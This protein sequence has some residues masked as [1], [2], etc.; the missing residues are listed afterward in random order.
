MSLYSFQEYTETG[1]HLPLFSIVLDR[2]EA[3]E[4]GESETVVLSWGWG[5]TER[6]TEPGA[7]RL[8]PTMT[9][10]LL[11]AGTD[12]NLGHDTCPSQLKTGH[13][14]RAGGPSP[15]WRW[16]ATRG[17]AS[18]ECGTWV[19]C[20]PGLPEQASV[21]IPEET[22]SYVKDK[23]KTSFCLWSRGDDAVTLRSWYRYSQPPGLCS[24][25]ES[26][27]HIQLS[28]QAQVFKCSKARLYTKNE[29]SRVRY[30]K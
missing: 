27:S 13:Q 29:S 26:P 19:P 28:Y 22:K 10:P 6:G 25:P 11:S 12:G 20:G 23:E 2:G 5:P 15:L 16:A 7:S 3:G 18:S 21:Y 24:W 14:Q 8:F 4:G 1:F 9:R 17:L 30:W